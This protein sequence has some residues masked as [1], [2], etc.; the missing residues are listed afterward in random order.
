MRFP[1]GARVRILKNSS[2]RFIGYRG[3]VA[4][5]NPS[6][7]HKPRAVLIENH[8]GEKVKPIMVD[9]SPEKTMQ[10]CLEV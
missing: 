8:F 6:E 3:V 2:Q 1:R 10:I 5:P 9:F 4:E 7:P